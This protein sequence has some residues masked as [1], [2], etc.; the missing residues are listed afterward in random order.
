MLDMSDR[1]RPV[2][3]TVVDYRYIPNSEHWTGDVVYGF[4]SAGFRDVEHEVAK[5]PQMTRVAVIGDS[6]TIDYCRGL[7][8]EKT[9]SR[10][11]RSRASHGGGQ[12][13]TRVHSS[14]CGCRILCRGWSCCVSVF[15]DEPAAAG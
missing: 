13:L 8:V 12:V 9:D 3:D 4:N 10:S 14:S 2:D 5:P 15:V 6:V 1:I 11:Q 7:W